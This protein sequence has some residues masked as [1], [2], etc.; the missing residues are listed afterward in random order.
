[1]SA[2]LQ[3][4][5]SSAPA[6]SPMAHVRFWKTELSNFPSVRVMLKPT[7]G[8]HSASREIGTGSPGY[9]FNNYADAPAGRATLEVFSAKQTAPLISLPINLAPGAL[10]TVLLSEPTNAGGVPQVEIIED[11]TM[12]TDAARAQLTVRS[13][14]ADLKDVRLTVGENLN[15][16]FVSGDCFL[17]M[18]GLKPALY[19][20]RTVG[21]GADS[22]PFDWNIDVDLRE[23]RHQTLL[24]YPDPYGRI[25]P[26]LI[27]DGE[28]ETG[29]RSPDK[30]SQ[31]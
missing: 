27:T 22:K 21:A 29:P 9:A 15:A 19:P 11:D 6:A 13:F 4:Q 8:R 3:A 31:R 24:I 5:T 14:V 10:A 16:Q 7:G 30:N 2:T 18:R 23:H 28:G 12:I 20:L 25:R 1:M 26:R 17:Q